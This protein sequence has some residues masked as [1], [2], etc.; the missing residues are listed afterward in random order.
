MCA[1]TRRRAGVDDVEH[2]R[3]VTGGEI[4]RR[5]LIVLG[6]ENG[7]HREAAGVQ[8]RRCAARLGNHR[9]GF[10]I[11]QKPTVAARQPPKRID[12]D[13]IGDDIEDRHAQTGA[14]GDLL[15]QERVDRIRAA[16]RGGL[17]A[18]EQVEQL[19]LFA[20]EESEMA[21]ERFGAIDPAVECAPH[22]RRAVDHRQIAAAR[23]GV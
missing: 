16:H 3:V 12:A 18:F 15:H 17:F 14:R 6:G 9:G 21:R 5:E 2:A 1:G 22:A 10:V 20:A 4:G 7:L 19:G 23:D 8:Q 11:G 13:R